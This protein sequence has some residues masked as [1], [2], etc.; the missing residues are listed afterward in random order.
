MKKKLKI[1]SSTFENPIFVS[2][3]REILYEK[4]R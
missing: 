4:N 1:I 3:E 2:I